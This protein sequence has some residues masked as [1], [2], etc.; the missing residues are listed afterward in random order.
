MGE[1]LIGSQK[2]ESLLFM[3]KGCLGITW[4]SREQLGKE[5]FQEGKF[6]RNLNKLRLYEMHGERHFIRKWSLAGVA[7]NLNRF[8]Q[9][10][11][12]VEKEFLFYWAKLSLI[13]ESQ[14]F[15]R[16]FSTCKKQVMISSAGQ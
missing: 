5:E 13:R 15:K 6:S 9:N 7:T 14:G 12:L 2:L 11:C 3:K 10:R 1:S 16:I 4:Y 8:F